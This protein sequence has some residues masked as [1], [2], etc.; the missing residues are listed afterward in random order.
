MYELFKQHSAGIY[1]SCDV[2]IFLMVFSLFPQFNTLKMFNIYIIFNER[3]I[4]LFV[5]PVTSF[6]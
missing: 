1:C 5:N 6:V 3:K 2:A 4:V